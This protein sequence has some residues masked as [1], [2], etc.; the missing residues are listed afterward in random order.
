MTLSRIGCQKTFAR[1]ASAALLLAW[2]LVVVNCETIVPRQSW[3][4]KWGPMVPHETFPGDCSICH[5]SE[6]W[7]VL[8]ED[9]EFDHAKETGFALEGAHEGAACLRCHNDRGPVQAYVTRGCGG[10]H[11][12]SHKGNLGA[13]CTECH[14]QNTW[15]PGGLVADHAKTRFPLVAIHAITPCEGCHLRATVGDFR[16]TPV[17]CHLC[18]QRDAIK[19]QPNHVLSGWVTNC[20]RCHTPEN[21]SAPGFNHD[22][23]PLLGG[24]AGV[25]CIQC[26]AGG[27]VGPIPPDCFA[28]HQND[29]INAPNHV[30]ENRPTDCTLCHNIFAWE[31]V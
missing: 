20:E 14:D 13:D 25:D 1:V 16:G 24:H 3:S 6:R 29:Y 8:R 21:W 19:A 11:V 4:K 23:F 26:H 7:D 5:V 15:F 9:F 27:Q 17:N 22:F 18:H 10:C 12:D 2:C 31:D 28:C 30:T